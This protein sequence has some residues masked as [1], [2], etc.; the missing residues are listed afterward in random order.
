MQIVRIDSL[1]G[2][3]P[4]GVAMRIDSPW[5]KG[6][7]VE[8]RPFPIACDRA[9]EIVGE[10]TAGVE[11]P[12]DAVVWL[13]RRPLHRG[14]MHLAFGELSEQPRPEGSW[15]A[16]IDLDPSATWAHPCL[17]L[18]VD[19]D[20]VLRETRERWFPETWKRDFVRAPR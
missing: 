13:S 11:L 20:G 16:L 5:T 9:L 17:Y 15:V 4:I 14:E 6:L 1:Y 12:T 19:A 18:F 2:T 10:H 8:S 7:A 3:V